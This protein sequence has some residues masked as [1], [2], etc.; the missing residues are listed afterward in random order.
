MA[1]PLR[2]KHFQATQLRKAGKSYSQIKEVL[3]VSKSTLSL[4]LKDHPLSND[5]IYELQDGNQQRVE[6]FRQT[7][8]QKR[9]NRTEEAV[10]TAQRTLLPLT[11]KERYLSGLFLYWGEGLKAGHSTVSL[12]NTDPQMM[13][14]FRQ[15]ALESLS[16]PPNRLKVRLHLYTDMDTELETTFWSQELGI[17]KNQF[18]KPH[19]KT[20]SQEKIT[21]KSFLHGTCEVSFH[22]AQIKEEIM[23]A[24][25][26]IG[27]TP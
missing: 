18:L 13:R 25:K 3:D 23:A 11:V 5:Q 20:S 1:K 2:E 7:M 8:K 21:Y 4:W 17:P 26:A 10:A 14:F 15:W 6:R 9:Q 27:I 16:I 19:I 22:H 12:S 24:I